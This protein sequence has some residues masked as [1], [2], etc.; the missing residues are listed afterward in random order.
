MYAFSA[1]FR[2][3]HSVIR[4]HRMRPG[5]FKA[6]LARMAMIGSLAAEIALIHAAEISIPRSEPA[7]VAAMEKEHSYAV[8]RDTSGNVVG[9]V[10][11]SEAHTDENFRA[12]ATISTLKRLN[13]SYIHESGPTKAGVLALKCASNLTELTF[14]CS[15]RADDL[16]P[17]LSQLQQI[18]MLQLV[19]AE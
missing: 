19:A 10:L 9:L 5:R 14:R 4:S 12:I 1:V 3:R 6:R 16:L 17:T 18:E 15:S 7:I 2:H 8:Q 11:T 13:F